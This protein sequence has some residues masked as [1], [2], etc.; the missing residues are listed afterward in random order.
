VTDVNKTRE[1]ITYL[2]EPGGSP[3]HNEYALSRTER[4]SDLAHRGVG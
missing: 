2:L 1:H 4:S 3:R